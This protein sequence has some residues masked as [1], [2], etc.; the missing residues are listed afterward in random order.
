QEQR[1]QK[2]LDVMFLCDEWKSSKGGL[3]TFNREFAINLAEATTGSMKIHCYVSNSDDQ[4]REDA[5][6]HGVN[7]ITARSVPGSADP[8]E[9]LKFPPSKLPK[10]HLVIGHGRKL[11]SPAYSLDLGK[12]KES[13]TA[14]EDTIEENEEKHKMEI[15][16][17]KA[18]DAVVA[19]G[20]R[21]QQKYSRRLLNVEVKIITPGIFG[22]FSSESKLAVDRS[23][24][25][26]F[27]VSM[28]GRATFED[29]SLKG[30]DLIANAI[31]SLGKNFELTFVGSSPGEQ[32][33]VEQ[34]FLDNT[35]INRNQLTIRRYCSEQEELKVMFY[36]SDLV[37]LPSRTEGF[38]LVALEAISA[39][40]PVLVSD[41]SGIAEAL[42]KVEGGNT[43]IVGSGEDKDEWARRIREM[44]EESAEEREANAVKLRENYR[45]VYSWKAECERFKGLIGNLII[46]GVAVGSLV[47]TVKCESLMI[48]EELWTDYSSGHLGEVVQNCFVT[49]KIL[50][51]LNLAELR[52]KTTIDIEEYN[53]CKTFFEKDALR[54]W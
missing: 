22:K 32:R 13:A 23:V 30:Y 12:Y 33:K 9:C 21:L 43:V 47:I 31:G 53:A 41:E 1:E 44:Y 2:V 25:K 15:E 3:S 19:V 48:L 42:Q 50:K 16:L 35:C 26:N 51:E 40:I 24:V 38:G 18:A 54:G 45:K 11:G 27:N 17:C 8:L 4:D 37:A 39:G 5:E 20:S 52:L 7:L 28:F 10:P 14:A 6:Q 36:Q 49:E 34:W 29:L 46:T